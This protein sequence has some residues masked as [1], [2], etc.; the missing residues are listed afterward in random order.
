MNQN[1][2]RSQQQQHNTSNNTAGV[3]NCVGQL[4]LFSLA[5]LRR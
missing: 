5:T 4:E 2:D 3:V 1:S